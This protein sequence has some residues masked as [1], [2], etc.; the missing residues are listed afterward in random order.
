MALAKKWRYPPRVSVSCPN[1]GAVV[2][3]REATEACGVHSAPMATQSV[4][5]APHSP[6]P[7]VLFGGSR[8]AR[9]GGSRVATVA[10][11]HRRANS[12][13]IR[14]SQGESNVTAPSA[15]ELAPPTIDLEILG[16]PSSLS[17]H[18]C[19]LIFQLFLAFS[20]RGWCSQVCSS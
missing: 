14:C 11:L 13:T 1:Y 8:G 18:S 17:L 5:R 12:C 20:A 6:S 9:K 16:V 15:V 2:F 4:V 10:W 3:V 7:C 19:T